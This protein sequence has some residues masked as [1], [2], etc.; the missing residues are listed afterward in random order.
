MTMVEY[1]G[2]DKIGFQYRT[3]NGDWCAGIQ[4]RRV[5][6]SRHNHGYDWGIVSLGLFKSEA[7]AN[8]AL[9]NAIVQMLMPTGIS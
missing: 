8:T 2:N 9:D 3:I 7:D 6:W 1:I 4:N 5:P